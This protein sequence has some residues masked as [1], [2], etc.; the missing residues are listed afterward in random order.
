MIIACFFQFAH[1]QSQFYKKNLAHSIYLGPDTDF[2]VNFQVTFQ[3]LSSTFV[4]TIIIIVFN[5]DD[6]IIISSSSSTSCPIGT[7]NQYEL[8]FV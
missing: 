1:V 4:N 7:L 8:V 6:N 5:I 3:Y 2:S